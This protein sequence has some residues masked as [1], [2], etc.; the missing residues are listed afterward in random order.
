MSRNPEVRELIAQQSMGMADSAVDEVRERSAS[1]DQW[2]ERL[3]HSL[4]HRPM[5]EKPAKPA[6]GGSDGTIPPAGEPAPAPGAAV[7]ATTAP[8]PVPQTAA[9]KTRKAA[10]TAATA[11]AARAA[12]DSGE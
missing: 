11:A 7:V 1:A 3:A 9:A 2:I 10:A 12:S 8:A 5:G 6:D 4:L